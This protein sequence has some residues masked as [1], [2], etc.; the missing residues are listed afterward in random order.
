MRVLQSTRAVG[1]TVL[2][3]IALAA[4]DA[5]AVE[6]FEKSAQAYREGRFQAAV[7]LL[8]EARKLKAEPVLLYNL[9]RA[10][11]A[12]GKLPEAVDAYSR[13]LE[14]DPGTA[15]RRAI[16]GRIATMRREIEEKKKR[17]EAPPPLPA[18]P[19]PIVV[20]PPPRAPGESPWPWLV[21]GAGVVTLG[22]GIGF[23]LLASR[24]EDESKSEPVQATAASLHEDA[25][26]HATIA[27]VTL[28]VG[29]AITV[30]GAV[31]LIVRLLSKSSAPSQAAFVF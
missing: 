9:G 7:E 16:E 26:S 1:I 12:Q 25:R 18:P 20:V 19:Q 2:L 14:E 15:D 30:A 27:N 6:L 22:V 5:R 21:T 23:G 24:K 8:L 29:A 31:W 17:D 10:Y 4:G 28:T 3:L 11:E 13:Y